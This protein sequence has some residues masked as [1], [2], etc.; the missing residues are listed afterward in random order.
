MSFNSRCF[1]G[2]VTEVVDGNTIQ[3]NGGK[4]R[5]AFL[6]APDLDDK[7]GME[8]KKFIEVLCP[9]GSDVLFDQDDLQPL[10]RYFGGVGMM[11]TSLGVIYCNGLNLNEELVESKYGSI[12]TWFCDNSEFSNM[13]WVKKNGC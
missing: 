5:L 2:T 6:P 13:E 11:G 9:V 12:S 8:T 10:D 1:T 4:V 3:I 7:G